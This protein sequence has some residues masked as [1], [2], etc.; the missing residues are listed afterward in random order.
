MDKGMIMDLY[1]AYGNPFI[2]LVMIEREVR[3]MCKEGEISE[4]EM[5]SLIETARK[6][7]LQMSN[8]V[9]YDL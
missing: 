5:S 7:Y 9:P 3:E 2:S 8:P 1:K 6:V 4:A